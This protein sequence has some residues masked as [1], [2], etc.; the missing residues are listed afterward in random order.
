MAKQFSSAVLGGSKIYKENKGRS[1]NLPCHPCQADSTSK[2]FDNSE[3]LTIKQLSALLEVSEKTIYG[4]TYRGL[5]PYHK[6][7]PRLVRFKKQE[8]ERWL[9]R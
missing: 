9:Q 6:V 2:L 7:G 5:I 3:Y 8:I 1:R 4:W